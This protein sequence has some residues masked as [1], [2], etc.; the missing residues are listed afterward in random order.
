MRLAAGPDRRSR[1]TR[2]SAPRSSSG[3]GLMR[4]LEAA[5]RKAGVRILLEHKMTAI[6]RENGRSG[7][8]IGIAGRQQRHHGQHP[9][10][11]GRHH[12]HRRLDRQRQ[13]PPHVRS[14]ADRGVLRSRRH[15][16]V[17]PGRQR[18]DRRH[19]DRRVAVGAVQLQTSEIGSGLTKPGRSAPSTAIVKSALAAG[20]P[21]VR[22]GARHRPA[23]HRL[24]ERDPGQHAGQAVLRRDGPAVH[25][26]QLQWRSRT[27]STAA[28]STPRTSPTSPTT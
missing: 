5:A 28:S 7:R 10:P 13:L 21:G 20:Q 23:G 26:Q 17:G 9:R 14:A 18:R 2:T 27:T 22:Q 4:P 11:Q 19:G 1:P 15:A 6:Y 16:L 24:A 8:V 12:R 3:N 25:R